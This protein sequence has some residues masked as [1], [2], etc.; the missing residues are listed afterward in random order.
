[1]KYASGVPIALMAL[2]ALVLD[3]DTFRRT[4]FLALLALFSVLLA[5]HSAINLSERHVLALL[6]FLFCYFGQFLAD[7]LGA[8]GMSPPAAAR[9]VAL[10]HLFAGVAGIVCILALKGHR[11]FDVLPK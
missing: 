8:A 9:R 5:W 2:I 7:V 1:V 11:L 6:P 3:R 4:F 10:V